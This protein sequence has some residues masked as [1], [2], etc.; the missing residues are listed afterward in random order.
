MSPRAREAAAVFVFD[1]DL[2]VRPGGVSVRN[3]TQQVGHLCGV[4]IRV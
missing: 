3:T 4:I 2:K 1:A